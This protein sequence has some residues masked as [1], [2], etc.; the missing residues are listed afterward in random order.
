[1]KKYDI[2]I[3]YS[4]EDI[5]VVEPFVRDL[6]RT[7]GVSCWID[8]TG[9]ESG[10]QF[11]EVIV[12]AI[13]SVEVVLFFLSENSMQSKYVKM[14][15][16]YAYNENVS[17]KVVPIVIDGG[18]LR[19]WFLFRFGSV[20]YIDINNYR[21]VEKLKHNLSEWCSAM[22]ATKQNNLS[23][24]LEDKKSKSSFI[25]RKWYELKFGMSLK[26]HWLLNATVIL[27][28]IESLG[29]LG[30]WAF[31]C[32]DYG[33]IASILF[34]SSHLSL[35]AAAYLFLI[36]RF[37]G[38]YIAVLSVLIYVTGYFVYGGSLFPLWNLLV[39]LPLVSYFPVFIPFKREWSDEMLF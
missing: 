3:S 26:E 22:P 29:Y 37:Y 31:K 34:V 6:E 8:W 21:Q 18:K 5:A 35:F 10:S 36:E 33:I 7:V 23:V 1:M 16:S 11:E 4:R 39:M 25:K 17:K 38:I 14:E 24:N 15:I 13:N 30:K 9:I 19:D 20:D 32:D 27:F 28:A 2:F 12:N